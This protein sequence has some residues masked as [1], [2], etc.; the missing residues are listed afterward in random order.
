MPHPTTPAPPTTVP[1]VI[2]RLRTIAESL[3]TSDGVAVFDAMYLD[4]T[5]RI[6][7]EL[8]AGTFRDPEFMAELDVRFAGY[9]LSA[10][11]AGSG[12]VAV[13][14]AWA[15]LFE[16][17]HTPGLL[18]VQYALAGMNAHIEHDLPLAVV[19]T[20]KARGVDL[21][22]PAVRA[23]YDAVNDVL[24]VVEGEIRR[25]FLTAIGH[26]VDDEV[27]PLMHLL[28]AWNIDKAR[29]LAWVSAE[30]IWATRRLE[31]LTARFVA[32]LGH[33]VGMGSRVL[34]TRVAAPWP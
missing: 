10:Y 33:T 29:D 34:L 21:D 23:D 7:A 13:P 26:Q 30:T 25:S 4:V 9:W 17:R 15:P 27:G 20:C 28:S 19:E 16:A 8:Q 3:P 22:E 24:A 31:R 18:R 2:V 14:S 1:Q 5:E 32:M 11:D 12:G 6:D